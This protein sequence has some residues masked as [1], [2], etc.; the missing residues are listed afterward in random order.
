[1]AKSIQRI[2]R[3]MITALLLRNVYIETGP[4]TTIAIGLIF[5]GSEVWGYTIARWSNVIETIILSSHE[6]KDR[7]ET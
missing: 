1:M 3:W 7:G 4:W 6:P 5:V 2:T